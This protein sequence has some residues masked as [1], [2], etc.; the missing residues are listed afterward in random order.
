MGKKTRNRTTEL[1]KRM[2][3]LGGGQLLLHIEQGKP[4]GKG[5]VEL[6]SGLDRKTGWKKNRDGS[7]G[8]EGSQSRE[9][10]S[11]QCSA[12]ARKPSAPGYTFRRKPSLSFTPTTSNHFVFN[13]SLRS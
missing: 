2:E 13:L 11:G 7:W 3:G 9:E 4:A 12:D 8:W 6:G 1:R 5:Q 10:V